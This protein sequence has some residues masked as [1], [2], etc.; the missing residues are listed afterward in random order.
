[1]N[2]TVFLDTGP[3]GLLTNPR[4]PAVTV[5]AMKWAVSMMAAGHLALF[6]PADL[7]TNIAP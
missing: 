6:A 2:R 1:M 5:A 3:L 7:W 4:K